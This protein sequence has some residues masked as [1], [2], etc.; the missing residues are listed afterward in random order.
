[1]CCPDEEARSNCYR[2]YLH[3]AVQRLRPVA[4]PTRWP[5]AGLE[6]G[7]RTP[8][9][10][11]PHQHHHVPRPSQDARHHQPPSSLHSHTQGKIRADAVQ[12][13]GRWVHCFY[14]SLCVFAGNAAEG[15]CCDSGD[16]SLPTDGLLEGQRDGIQTGFTGRS[17]THFF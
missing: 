2:C 14:M 11:L 7:A 6:V 13:C 15:P 3:R 17:F 1:M 10:K 5:P 4:V 12:V 8:S 16:V 9:Q